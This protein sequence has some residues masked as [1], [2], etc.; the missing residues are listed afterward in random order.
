MKRM[1]MAGLALSAAAFVAA[2]PIQV[3]VVVVA[4][5]ER[6]ESTGDIPG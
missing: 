4:M 3:K 1:L 6:G 5:F 2:E